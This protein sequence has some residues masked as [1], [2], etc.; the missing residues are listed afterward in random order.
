[1]D[2]KNPKIAGI[3]YLPIPIKDG[4]TLVRELI[5]DKFQPEMIIL[6]GSLATGEWTWK[7]DIDILIVADTNERPHLELDI[8]NVITESGIKKKVSRIISPVVVS[9]ELLNDKLEIGHYFF[10][11]IV[12]QGKLL[13]NTG[14][15]SLAEMR[16][17]EP[18][19]YVIL[20]K[21]DFDYWREEA[22]GF[23]EGFE[24]Y[25]QKNLHKKRCRHA[26]FLLHQVVEASCVMVELVYS[27]HRSQTHDLDELMEKFIHFVSEA[28]T[29]FPQDNEFQ[30]QAYK[31]LYKAYIAARYDKE[32]QIEE[33]ELKYLGERVK[34]LLDLAIR[35]CEERVQQILKEPK[36]YIKK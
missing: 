6:F 22:E 25:L 29:I 3:E 36:K 19:E 7:S 32:Y 12:K 14:R 15:F 5:V 13:Y 28:A 35:S 31:R 33:A 30:K 21:D 23:M 27:R 1:M 26:A 2:R 10:D 17:L 18:E 16:E 34:I 9:P 11:D 24:F 20:V 8:R 4:L